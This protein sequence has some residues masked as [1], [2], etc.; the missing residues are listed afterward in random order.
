MRQLPR[1]RRLCSIASG[2][3][4]EAWEWL[5]NHAS[6]AA[7]WLGYVPFDAISDARNEAPVISMHSKERPS[8]FVSVEPDIIL[9]EVED[10]EPRIYLSGFEGRQPYRL[11]FYGEKTSLAPILTPIAKRFKADLYLPTGEISDT[12]LHI[13]AKTGAEDGRR[14]IV[15]TLSDFDPAGWQMAVSIGRKLQAFRDLHFPN[16]EFEVRPIALTGDQARRLGLPETPLKETERRAAKW[17]EKMGWEQTEIDALATLAPAVLNRIIVEA[18][19]PFYDATLTSPGA[20]A[21][22]E[23]R[24]LA[25]EA[26]EGQLTDDQIATLRVVAVE[27]LEEIRAALRDLESTVGMAAGSLDI[28]LPE[29]VVPEPEIDESLQGKPLISSSWSWVDQTRALI[30]R[31]AYDGAGGEE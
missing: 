23:Y 18:V 11:A 2:N 16:L 21:K 20:E 6:K 3:A 24:D 27:K 15:F 10:L 1:P 17:R 26:L 30:A 13:M 8:A 9:P 4:L 12:Q 14:L 28:D 22:E 25:Q 29:A 19:E 31:K 7:R 5:Q